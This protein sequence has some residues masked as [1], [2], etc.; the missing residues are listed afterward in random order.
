MDHGAHAL[1]HLLG[2]CLLY[3]SILH[4]LS[5]RI[6]GVDQT[7]AVSLVSLDV[8]SRV[9]PVSYTHLDVYKRQGL[10]EDL[11]ADCELVVEAAFEDMKVKQTTFGE[12]D[13]IC[14]PECIFASNTSRCV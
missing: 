1:H 7:D 5:L 2:V 4:Q 3:T 8:Q 14:K 9:D 10:K 6:H 12:L 11:C 13:K